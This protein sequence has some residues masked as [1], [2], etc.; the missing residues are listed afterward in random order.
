MDRSILQAL[1]GFL[2]LLAY[3]PLLGRVVTL[4]LVVRLELTRVLPQRILMV[5]DASAA[6]AHPHWSP[7]S[8]V[9]TY[10]TI[11]AFFI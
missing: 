3:P 11:P 10:S 4:V 6:L 8:A 2:P 1:F 5:L 9:S 7:A